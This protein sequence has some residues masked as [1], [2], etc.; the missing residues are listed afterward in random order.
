MLHTLPSAAEITAPSASGAAR[1]GSRKKAPM[2]AAASI[3]IA[4][5]HTKPAASISTPA[6]ATPKVIGTP[7]TAIPISAAIRVAK[8][9]DALAAPLSAALSKSRL[10]PRAI[11]Q[12][13]AAQP[14]HESAQ[15]ASDLFDRMLF[16]VGAHLFEI[17]HSGVI[18]ADPLVRK[19]A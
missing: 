7:S 12:P 6:T 11:D 15:L 17:L 1:S 19:F 14:R 18:L 10:V 4:P 16:G 8:R 5:S 2:A 3:T 9:C 13:L